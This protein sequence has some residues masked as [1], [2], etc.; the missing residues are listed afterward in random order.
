MAYDQS[1]IIKKY[2]T[3]YDYLKQNEVNLRQLS[4][5]FPIIDLILNRIQKYEPLNE[6]GICAGLAME[7][8]RGNASLDTEVKERFKQL[9][10]VMGDK[11]V[12][13][14]LGKKLIESVIDNLE[15]G[16]S[17]SE[18]KKAKMARQ[19]DSLS[20]VLD[21]GQDAHLLWKGYTSVESLTRQK[22]RRD[23][24]VIWLTG[25]PLITNNPKTLTENLTMMINPGYANR[26]S[27][28]YHIMA[29]YPKKDKNKNEYKNFAY[30]PNEVK[31]EVSYN[32]I[33]ALSTYVTHQLGPY[34]SKKPYGYDIVL[35]SIDPNQTLNI[36]ELN[37]ITKEN[38]GKPILIKQ[39]NQISIYGF[40]KGEW[41]LT[42][43]DHS[44]FN[45]F[46]FP[47][48][49]NE[50]RLVTEADVT[51][52][53]YNEIAKKNA[54][55]PP[56]LQA[57]EY[58]E[59]F[60]V[61]KNQESTLFPKDF[62]VI[63]DLLTAIKKTLIEY[64]IDEKSKDTYKAFV[65]IYNAFV[66]NA[67]PL[68]KTLSEVTAFLLRLTGSPEGRDKKELLMILSALTAFER[69]PDIDRCVHIDYMLNGI[70]NIIED[71]KKNNN[72]L[73]KQ[74]QHYFDALLTEIIKYDEGTK[75]LDCI[76]RNVSDKLNTLL[77]LQ[78]QTISKAFLRFKEHVDY[79][80][81][82]WPLLKNKQQIISSLS[83]KPNEAQRTNLHAVVWFRD[84]IGLDHLL[85]QPGI[86]INAVD[87]EG[88]TPLFRAL[89]LGEEYMFARLLDHGAKPI[90]KQIPTK[91]TDSLLQMAVSKERFI[92][93]V[94]AL[95][96]AGAIN[97]LGTLVDSTENTLFKYIFDQAKQFPKQFQSR[98]KEYYPIFE[99]LIKEHKK[100]IS[101]EDRAY[102]AASLAEIGKNPE[103]GKYD[104]IELFLEEE[105]NN[106]VAYNILFNY[107]S[108]ETAFTEV[109]KDSE[110]YSILSRV[111]SHL[112]PAFMSEALHHCI[113][114]YREG[115]ITPFSIFVEC[116]ANNI[117]IETVINKKNNRGFMPLEIAIMNGE[118]D[119][120]S[121]LLKHGAD[122]L[123]QNDK[124]QNAIHRA[125]LER[126][127][128][129]E[130]VETLLKE[131][132]SLPDLIKQEDKDRNSPIKYMWEND[133]LKTERLTILNSILKI[134]E[135]KNQWSEVKGVLDTYFA[136]QGLSLNQICDQA[137]GKTLLHQSAEQGYL[138]L[139]KYLV[140]CKCNVNAKDNKEQTP[141]ALANSHHQEEIE[142]YFR[143]MARSENK[144]LRTTRV[145]ALSIF[146]EPSAKTAGPDATPGSPKLK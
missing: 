57:I 142:T 71:Y 115:K 45:K 8:I 145:S 120:V 141:M 95:L 33:D 65:D 35:L 73:Y 44:V 55:T 98:Y 4:K 136:S 76:L 134:A 32:S 62:R 110:E 41:K 79:V 85:K 23:M 43:L 30:D 112:D 89:E 128:N 31:G 5:E 34:I 22:Y 78:D 88:K 40:T 104:L 16:K 121:T 56:G 99:A 75:P 49:V 26:V 124:G 97:T 106:P 51:Y 21:T 66:M 103:T 58:T 82:N 68:S 116:H 70:Q 117:P 18:K 54:Y 96:R 38:N 6:E 138:H 111:I 42:Q 93:Y 126:H 28:P 87:S 83:V 11:K 67:Q 129:H 61:D 36:N 7:Y 3:V 122:P 13:D 46:T 118:A 29:V 37:N 48:N 135:E 84:E 14:I 125:F 108:Q 77:S 52:E 91:D 53:I 60:L 119:I 19:L 81:E 127:Y 113:T 25:V 140:E 94:P 139:T 86:D 64:K 9:Q 2:N 92:K 72:D 130:I 47:E 69:H 1:E 100:V 24:K 133:A 90:D 101:L 107:L 123:L 27:S 50:T 114:R 17:I 80:N 74:Y 15:K 137:T 20:K 143:R 63:S 144:L 12:N 102:L 109:Q 132:K 105:K 131:T 146:K 39:G 59:V 10:T